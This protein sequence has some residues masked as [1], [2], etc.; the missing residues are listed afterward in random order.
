MY[1]DQFYAES[2]AVTRNHWGKGEVYYVATQ[3]EEAYLSQLLRSITEGCDLSGIQIL[4]H[5]VQVTTRSGPNGTF[6]FILNLS[7]EPASIE[8]HA[9]YTSALDGKPKG[10]H[11][12]LDGYAIEIL[13]IQ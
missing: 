12:E 2:A 13:E 3:P 8:L 10:P 4:S 9:S 11:L 1:A 6:R 5:G 7:P